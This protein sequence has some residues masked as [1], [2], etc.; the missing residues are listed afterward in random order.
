L[1]DRAGSL[2][3]DAQAL[4]DSELNSGAFELNIEAIDSERFEIF[5]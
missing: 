3:I 5:Q 1:A 4:V 2:N